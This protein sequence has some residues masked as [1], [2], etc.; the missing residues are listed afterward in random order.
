MS[1][2]P[3]VSPPLHPP[4]CVSLESLRT[5]SY[6][7]LTANLMESSSPFFWLIITHSSKSV[8]VSPSSSGP[9]Q[10][11]PP[12]NI[13]IHLCYLSTETTSSLRTAALCPCSISFPA[14]SS[15]RRG[16][17]TQELLAEF[18]PVIPG[19]ESWKENYPVVHAQVHLSQSPLMSACLWNTTH[20]PN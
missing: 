18:L 20:R 5:A 2:S 7:F 15:K 17:S 9:A 10:S 19:S 14:P 1:L 3:L 11:L 8:S 12:S 13:N 6:T 16:A 4:Q